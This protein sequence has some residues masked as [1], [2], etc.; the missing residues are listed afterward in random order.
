MRKLLAHSLCI[1]M[2]FVGAYSSYAQYPDAE[3][4][5]GRLGI[6]IVKDGKPV[7]D[8][9]GGCLPEAYD[10][11]TMQDSGKLTALCGDE[12]ALKERRWSS[13]CS[14]DASVSC[15]YDFMR[16]M[17]MAADTKGSFLIGDLVRSREFLAC[18]FGEDFILP[19]L[20]TVA[21]SSGMVYT[22]LT[23]R[24][25]FQ[26]CC[27]FYKKLQT[28]ENELGELKVRRKMDEEDSIVVK[29]HSLC[30]K[31]HFGWQEKI[32]SQ[33]AECEKLL[34]KH[35]PRNE[36][37]KLLW[38]KW[39][40]FHKISCDSDQKEVLLAKEDF[41]KE[42]GCVLGL[43]NYKHPVRIA[44]S[45]VRILLPE[46]LKSCPLFEEA[47][48]ARKEAFIKW[49]KEE[50]KVR[51]EIKKLFEEYRKR[52]GGIIALHGQSFPT[53]TEP[54]TVSLEIYQEHYEGE[55]GT[56]K[57]YTEKWKKRLEDLDIKLRLTIDTRTRKLLSAF[58][59]KFVVNGQAA[60]DF[61]TDG[62]C[63]FKSKQP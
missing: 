34:K 3:S 50:E 29:N 61:G 23:S 27:C 33:I 14:S 62:L 8:G 21:E 41:L 46:Y 25:K 42:L 52:F 36:R 22:N 26:E 9:T 59:E 56:R 28:L 30:A 1:G 43:Q 17:G 40:V 24:I 44:L 13:H 11:L 31:A 63:I 6:K 15:Y 47:Y 54:V 7:A 53:S 32:K 18:V 48:Q 19:F 58:C 5:L 39:S 20:E 10:A 49:E 57:L 55:D 38:E 16:K 12:T 45:K 60:T 51:N 35:V 4:L 37:Y 2:A